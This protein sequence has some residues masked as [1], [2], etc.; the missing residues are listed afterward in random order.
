MSEE[1]YAYLARHLDD[2]PG[3]FPSTESGVELRILKRLFSPEQAELAVR[4]TITPEA[5]GAIAERSGL[6]IEET[7]KRL[8]VMARKGLIFS[9]EE[10][11]RPAL[12][13]AASYI[14]GIW[15]FQLNNLNKEFARDM[16]E[17]APTLGVE[18]SKFPQLRTIPV[19]RSI[20]ASAEVFPHEGAG[21]LVQ[22]RKKILVAPCIC[23]RKTKTQGAGCDKPE[24][25]C[26][27]FDQWAEYYHRNG[28]GRIIGK[29]E[30]LE[31][32]KKA[33]EAGL[34]LQPSNSKE[35]GWICCCC[36]CCCGA[37]KRLK[38]HPKPASIVVNSFICQV[39]PETCQGCRVCIDRCPTHAHEIVDDRVAYLPERCIGCGLCT[40][41][42]PSGA[43][44]M[45]RKPE[46]QH[47]SIPQTVMDNRVILAQ[48][49]GKA[50]LQDVTE[51][52]SA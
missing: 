16:D 42:C 12:Y 5:A 30:A 35:P 22:E 49:R 39:D 41:T 44:T 3:G 32:L 24:E 21:E 51:K 33:D 34:V 19:G 9:I 27:I 23:R 43:A 47:P 45:I 17:Y 6:D 18:I 36:S 50:G 4:L 52:K 7:A 26:L 14:F 46:N 28:L 13:Q 29:D 11:G 10:R 31:I 37:V 8:E 38:A 20:P 40:T 25:T 15:E 2:L 1:V 48:V